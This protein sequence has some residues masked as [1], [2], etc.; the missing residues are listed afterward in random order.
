[1]VQAGRATDAVLTPLPLIDEGDIIIDGGNAK[2]TD[3]I[4]REKRLNERAYSLVPGSVAEKKSTLWAFSCRVVQRK[5]GKKLRIYGMQFQ[6]KL[7][8]QTVSL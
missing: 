7:T 5:P 4:D 6:L 1:M 8:P 3:S 2:W